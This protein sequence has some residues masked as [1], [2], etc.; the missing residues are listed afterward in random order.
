MLMGLENVNL[1]KKYNSIL[2][3]RM[4][5]ILKELYS[6]YKFKF[7][8]MSIAD[9]CNYLT[10]LKNSM[11][12]SRILK[13]DIS[14]KYV[15]VKVAYVNLYKI[16]FGSDN[17][18]SYF[19]KLLSYSNDDIFYCAEVNSEELELYDTLFNERKLIERLSKEISYV[20]SNVNYVDKFLVLIDSYYKQFSKKR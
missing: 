15:P 20:D 3:I 9:K 18:N 7:D 2:E 17:M 4:Q 11:N 19:N 1:L 8:T 14:E 6:T 12:S 16:L 5:N 10:L 13:D